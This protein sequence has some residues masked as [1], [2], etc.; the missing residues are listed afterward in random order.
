MQMA[1]PTIPENMVLLYVVK[2]AYSC[3]QMEKEI[4]Q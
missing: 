3:V 1:F 2:V 4:E